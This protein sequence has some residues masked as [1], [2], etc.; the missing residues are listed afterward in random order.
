MF[1][2]DNFIE[3]ILGK[4]DPISLIKI[5][6]TIENNIAD[7]C[8]KRDST[9]S[10][11]SLNKTSENCCDK[12]GHR[13][14]RNGHTKSGVQKYICP[15]CGAT[16][17][18]RTGTVSSG[19]KLPFSVWKNVIDNILN[20]FSLRRIATENN[21]SLD[22]SFRLRHK[23]CEAINELIKNIKLQGKVWSDA[24]YFSLNFKGTKTKNMPR[25]SKKR[26]SK[27]SLSG[28]SHHKLCVIGAI[29][30]FDNLVLKIGGLGKG[31]SVMLENCLGDKIDNAKEFTSDS[32]SAYIS[33]CEK[34]NIILNQIPSGFNSDGLENLSEINNVHSQFKS[35][36]TKFK[37][38]STKH[39]QAYLNWFQYL[40]MMLRKFELKD[41]KYKN[42]KDIVICKN[43]IKS[44][45]IC[46]KE[47][48]IDPMEAYSEY[49][50]QSFA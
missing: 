30:E 4:L 42:Y 36:I 39:F 31:T 46:K 41:L 7:I 28:I 3:T 48:P 43:H 22:T 17:S 32:A 40:F 45:N 6:E 16:P 14:S 1:N 10:I 38:V 2:L 35:W 23:V 27:S 5:K 33:F 47:L 44:S 26:K 15:I 9:A 20:G 21:I 19:S 34:Y 49:F 50:H 37:G 29:D 18:E 25:K 11:I 13:L 8:C 24:Q 12:C